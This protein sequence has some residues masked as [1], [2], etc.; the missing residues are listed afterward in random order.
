LTGRWTDSNSTSFHK[1]FG[2][3]FFI[4]IGDEHGIGR[5]PQTRLLAPAATFARVQFRNF[6]FRKRPSFLAPRRSACGIPD[7]LPLW[8][9]RNN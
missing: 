9:I 2:C 4:P 3:Y 1:R 8:R 7:T 5:S 6:C